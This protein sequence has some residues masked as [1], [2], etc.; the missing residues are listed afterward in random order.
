MNT[1]EFDYELPRSLIAQE[2][3]FPR[4][5]SRLMIIEKDTG[6]INH[7]YFYN[8]PKYLKPDDLLVFNQSKVFPAR[9][10]GK[11][12]TGGKVEVL[13]LKPG[14]E[15]ISKPGLREGQEI[16]F[17]KGLTA[18]VINNKLIFNIDVISIINDIGYT[19]L[20]PYI[21]PNVIG[22][23]PKIRQMYQTVY[24]K[25]IG[26]AAAP[27]AGFHFTKELLDKIP[28]KEYVTLHVGL[29]TFL[30]VKT[31]KIEEHKMHSEWYDISPK[32]QKAIL[33]AKRVIAVGTTSVRVLESA[34]DKHETDIFI[35]PGYKFKHV[36][37]M[38]TNFHLPKSTLLMLV[39]AFAGRDLIMK[40]YKEAVKEKYRFFSF[41]DAM[42]II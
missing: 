9:L 39:S 33:A 42:L 29:G 5:H 25:D 1:F 34:W 11:K 37:G 18:K 17:D 16:V 30:P 27:T 31:D 8:L 26:S 20:P 13:L 35:Y 22:D 2:P 28:N 24:A 41:G 15:F 7:D 19:P 21:D 23:E 4:D 36:D 38:I 6:K 3:V 12:I 40:A 32:T 10:Y 14:W